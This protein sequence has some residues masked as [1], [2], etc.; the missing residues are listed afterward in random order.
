MK[1]RTVCFACTLCLLLPLTAC[2]P[3]GAVE[4]ASTTGPTQTSAPSPATSAV[5]EEHI[6]ALFP[7]YQI[8]EILPYEGDFL[9][10]YGTQYP[11]GFLS[12]VY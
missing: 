2:N 12:W 10:Y 9:V 5:T 4:P 1:L 8:R 6:P 11:P 7:D 3:K